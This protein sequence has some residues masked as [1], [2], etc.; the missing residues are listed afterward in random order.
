MELLTFTAAELLTPARIEEMGVLS[1]VALVMLA[2]RVA[3]GVTT[4]RP[5]R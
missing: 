5:G 4:A 1:Y 3:S 2:S